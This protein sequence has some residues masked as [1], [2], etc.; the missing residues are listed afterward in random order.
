MLKQV[1]DL[2]S[3]YCN[4]ERE[5]QR[6]RVLSCGMLIFEKIQYYNNADDDGSKTNWT[7]L[8]TYTLITSN[9]IRSKANISIL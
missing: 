3:T 1:F 8:V 9:T 7:I 4:L 5:S 2:N 6:K